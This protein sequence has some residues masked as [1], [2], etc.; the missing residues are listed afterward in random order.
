MAPSHFNYE[1]YM[2]EGIT[3]IHNMDGILV[4][5]EDLAYWY[6]LEYP[7]GSKV[8]QY[9]EMTNKKFSEGSGT[10]P[11]MLVG[12]SAN[13]CQ[14]IYIASAAHSRALRGIIYV[15]KR[16]VRT[17]ATK[18]CEMMGAEIN[19]VKPGYLSVVRKHARQRAVD[20]REV[21]EWDRKLAI[22]DTA[23]QCKNVPD[24]VKRIIVSTGSG[25]TAAGVLIGVAEK[26]IQ[27]VAVATS[28][29]AGASDII[30]LASRYSSNEK[31]R[32]TLEFIT[33]TVPYDKHRI[34]RLPDGTPLDP[35]YAAKAWHLT[36]PGDLFWPPGL[37]PI[38]SM[39][40]DCR[41]EFKDWKGPVK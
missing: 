38:M 29:M 25:L 35:F 20:L 7:S 18:Y 3:P 36:E 8:R 17:D 33:S 19:E 6:S 15:P 34:D 14:Q 27:V 12:C 28:P 30:K 11:P 26:D 22:L 39:P 10:L 32:A 9:S 16:A 23:E 37:R 1:V 41:V 13:S 4:K 2:Y 40:E 5:R 31:C 24:G 21:I